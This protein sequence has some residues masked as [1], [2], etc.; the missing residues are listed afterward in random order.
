M[1]NWRKLGYLAVLGI[2]F[3]VLYTFIGILLVYRTGMSI[4]ASLVTPLL[5]YLMTRIFFKPT[6]IDLTL[7]QAISSGASL[8]TFSLESAFAAT[9]IFHSAGIGT[10]LWHLIGLGLGMNFFGIL[11][12]IPFI[13]L[14]I[15]GENLPFP[16]GQAIGKVIHSF[17]EEKKS[18]TF[19]LIG[20]G[21]ASMGVYLVTR[22]K[23]VLINP[24]S[25][26]FP[27]PSFIGFE[28]SPLLFGLG[29]FLPFKA[30]LSLLIGAGYS[31]FIWVIKMGMDSTVAFRE[32]LFQ[33]LIFSVAIGL[34]LGH[35]IYSIPSLLVK[36]KEIF[37]NISKGKTKF[38]YLWAT[39]VVVL[40]MI[41]AIFLNTALLFPYYGVP[42]ILLIALLF[43]LV[44]A[45]IRGE[46]GLG[47]TATIYFTIPIVALFTKD[48]TTVLLLAGAATLMT[49]TLSDCLEMVRIGVITETPVNKILI[50][51]TIGSVAGVF[52]GSFTMVVLHSIYG[53]GTNIL[54]VPTSLAW[55][56]VASAVIGQG[57]PKSINFSL[58]FFGIFISI[59]LSRYQQSPL[60]IGMGILVPTSVIVT[61]FLGSYIA[62]NFIRKNSRYIP[63]NLGA[64]LVTGEGLM[65]MGS[66]ILSLLR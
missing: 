37:Q 11:I 43:S 58:I 47:T 57:F 9:I 13:S 36:M 44:T 3:G 28:L 30:A 24:V 62:R 21:I 19:Q 7:T 50:F 39:V 52:A 2:I 14:W 59:F 6:P 17:T 38:N 41:F 61:I 23:K 4:S 53:V 63:H 56:T 32:H 12:A 46:A 65:A 42:V 35:T 31:I 15:H 48:L 1:G 29:M 64:G 45:R 27:M 40:I 34:A 51:Y 49:V 20:S 5:F 22:I 25:G 60:L 26:F 18:D 16:K 66:G 55:G 8:A 33:P 10:T 54:P